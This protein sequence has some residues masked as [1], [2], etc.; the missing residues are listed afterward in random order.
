MRGIIIGRKLC[1]NDAEIEAS[2]RGSGGIRKL[3]NDCIFQMS[4]K[5]EI[6]CVDE[7]ASSIVMVVD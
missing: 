3:S 5:Y 2:N 6:I 7:M 1:V 4:A